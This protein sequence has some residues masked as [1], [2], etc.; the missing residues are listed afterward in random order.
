[1]QHEAGDSIWKSA[2]VFERDTCPEAYAS[3]V[4]FCNFQRANEAIEKVGVGWDVK[5]RLTGPRLSAAGQIRDEH[6]A[7]TGK[8]RCPGVEVFE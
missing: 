5:R 3:G 2:G 1:M 4:M 7:M 8:R 6:P